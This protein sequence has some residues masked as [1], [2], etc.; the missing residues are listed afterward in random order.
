MTLGIPQDA[1]PP[2]TPT[3]RDAGDYTAPLDRIA[4]NWSSV[5]PESGVLEYQYAIGTSAGAA[6]V[7]PWTSAGVATSIVRTG[8]SLTAGV[9]Y[10]VSVKARNGWD[11]WSSAG[12]SD[13]VVAIPS[14]SLNN[15]HGSPDGTLITIPS[16]VVTAGT[17]RFFWT[18]YVEAAD[19]SSGIRVNTGSHGVAAGDLV[20]VSGTIQTSQGERVITFPS[21][22]TLAH[23]V[24][25]PGPFLA[26]AR[27]IGGRPSSV[28]V[29]IPVGGAGAYNVGLLL[30]VAGA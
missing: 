11:V 18:F 20:A 21:V 26:G 1:T 27:D 13:G 28:C 23:S 6:D 17:D 30:A 25:V 12:T 7:A 4:A 24:P 8:L 9:R 3:V 29:P 19:R 16:A 2:S 5:D 10:F 22:G 14:T 15:V